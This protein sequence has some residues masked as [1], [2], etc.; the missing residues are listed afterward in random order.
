[1]F[2]RASVQ[3]YLQQVSVRNELNVV[4]SCCTTIVY[5]TLIRRTPGTYHNAVAISVFQNYLFF[6]FFIFTF[7]G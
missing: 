6:F 3:K 4:S 1:M 5:D 7:K 2:A